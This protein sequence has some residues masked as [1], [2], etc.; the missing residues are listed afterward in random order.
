MADASTTNGENGKM[1][2]PLAEFK[3][4]FVE[5]R[6][7]QSRLRHVQQFLKSPM[8]FDLGEEPLEVTDSP[9]AIEERKRELDYRIKVLQSLMTLMTEERAA[10]DRAVSAQ[11]P[12]APEQAPGTPIAKK[13]P[14][15][16]DVMADSRKAH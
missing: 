2:D 5:Q 11:A 10:L 7:Q 14:G 9:E 15:A 12:V 16:A 8:F 13:T 6:E 1:E 4:L 3:E